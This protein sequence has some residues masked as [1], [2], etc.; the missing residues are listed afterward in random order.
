M[1]ALLAPVPGK[2]FLSLVLPQPP[3]ANRLWRSGRTWGG[4]R[5]THP[6]DEYKAWLTEAGW[7][8]KRQAGACAIRGPYAMALSVPPS[9]RDLDNNVKP[10]GDLLQSVGLIENDRHLHCLL[11]AFDAGQGARTVRVEL[12]PLTTAPSPQ[13]S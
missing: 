9:R 4:Q 11:V 6:S 2:P 13:T 12:W 1:H 8:A 3:S 7:E 10:V 5:V